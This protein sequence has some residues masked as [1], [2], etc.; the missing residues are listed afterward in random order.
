[1]LNNLQTKVE[2]I[3]EKYTDLVDNRIDSAINEK[4]V[5]SI[6]MIEINNGIR[7]LNH[8]ASTLERIVRIQHGDNASETVITLGT[9]PLP[10][11][12]P[13]AVKKMVEKEA[14][15]EMLVKQLKLLSEQAEK[16]T[17]V[18]ELCQLNTAICKTIKVLQK[19]II[20]QFGI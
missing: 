2:T 11:L 15:M 3:A 1:M 17:E 16:T 13:P 12:S 7:M 8:V 5:D 4:E 18:E 10:L 6:A 19:Q 9:Q 20:H 14:V